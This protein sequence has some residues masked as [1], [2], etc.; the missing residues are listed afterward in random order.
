[1][2]VDNFHLANSRLKDIAIS[3]RGRKITYE[4]MEEHVQRFAGYLKSLGVKEGDRVALTA[5]NSPEFIFSFWAVNR[6]GAVAVPLNLFLTLEEVGYVIRN[7]G[8]ETLIA[9]PVI[10]EKAASV[11]LSTL[12]L[13]NVVVLNQDTLKDIYTSEKYTQGSA[14]LGD[15]CLSAILY[16]SGTTGKPKGA[17]LTHKNF[18]SNVISLTKVTEITRDDN[19]LCVLP[20]F[21]SF[22]WTVC[23]L[24]PLYCGGTVVVL[25]GF[26]PSETIRTLVEEKVTFLLGVPPMYAVFLKKAEPEHFKEVRI[27]VSGGAPLFPELYKAFTNKFSVNF[28]EGYGLTEASPVVCINPVHGVKK[29]GSIGLPIPGVSVIIGDEYGNEAPQGEIGEILVKGDNVM[30]GYYGDEE[31][32]KQAFVNGWLRTGD[33]A[34]ADKDGYI[35]IVDRKKDLIIVGG[36][37]VYPR[38]IEELLLTHPKIA[39]VAVV[40]IKDTL[41]GEVPKAFIVPVEGESLTAGEVLAFLKGKLAPYKIPRAVEFV[42]S[43]PKN[44]AGKIMKKL[45]KEN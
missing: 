7:S 24:L 42:E 14:H 6:I 44:P 35:Y 2:R 25:E 19:F 1:M 4:E 37:N 28:I 9:H 34:W 26:Q 15:E 36:F 11:D 30:Q 38:E 21:H 43:L 40:G 29:P 18:Y 45:L 16:T 22:A 27:A 8:A 32:T 39:E 31:A 5:P 13:K 33:M 20:M 3:H 17:M 10:L 41:K 12:G 23:V